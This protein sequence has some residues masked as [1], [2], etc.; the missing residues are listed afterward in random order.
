MKLF[1]LSF[2]FVLAVSFCAN[3]QDCESA[4]ST[5]STVRACL[6]NKLDKDLNSA[7][8]P[9]YRSLLT[10]KPAAAKL[11]QKSQ[12]SWGKFVEDSCAFVVEINVEDMLLEDA[13]Y[14][15]QLDF[16]TARIKVLKAW[17]AQS[18]RAP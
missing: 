18:R 5:M 2:T 9:L 13:R 6:Y 1:A 7:Y 15:C 3:G 8:Q 10:K 11:L 17:A 12:I 4:G 16:T 14:N